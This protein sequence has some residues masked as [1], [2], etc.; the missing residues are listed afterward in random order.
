MWWPQH[1][2]SLEWFQAG[3]AAD[4][5][6][7]A[8]LDAMHSPVKSDGLP[9]ADLLEFLLGR[10]VYIEVME[11]NTAAIGAAT[12]GYSPKMRY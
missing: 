8:E 2:S 7:V 4:A 1:G 6:A 12:A 5:T 9:I 11:D 3:V 10:P